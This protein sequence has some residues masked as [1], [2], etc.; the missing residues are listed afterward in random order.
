MPESA[1]EWIASAS[2]DEDAVSAKARNF[3]TAI[4]R[5]AV[6][7]A[8]TALVPPPDDMVPSF[9]VRTEVLDPD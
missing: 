4:D 8:T 6:S 9:T 2:I 7:A 3:I 1:T 5:F